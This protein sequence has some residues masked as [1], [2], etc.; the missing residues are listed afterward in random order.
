LEAHKNKLYHLGITTMIIGKKAAFIDAG[1]HNATFSYTDTQNTGEEL[2]PYT[3][4]AS[5]MGTVIAIDISLGRPE[6]FT[7]RFSLTKAMEIVISHCNSALED[8]YVSLRDNKILIASNNDYNGEGHCGNTKHAY[9][10]T[11]L[12]A[13]TYYVDS[14]GY[15]ENGYIT[16]TITGIDNQIPGGGNGDDSSVSSNH[17]YIKTRTYTTADGTLYLDA[18]QYFDG[19]GRPDRL[20]AVGITSDRKDLLSVQPHGP[21]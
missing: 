2:Y 6:K 16:T 9:I 8:T 4:D 20:V 15:R 18:V 12:P 7:Y 3:Q 11:V 13:G 21:A 1:T 17:N 5:T 14:E 10:K 19:L